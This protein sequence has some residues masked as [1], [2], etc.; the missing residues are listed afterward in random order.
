MITLEIV[1]KKDIVIFSRNEHGER[2]KETITN[3]KPYFYYKDKNGIYQTLF[4]EPCSKHISNLPMD[5]PHDSRSYDVCYENKIKYLQRFMVDRIN[6]PIKK[7]KLRKCFMDIETNDS[8]DTKKTPE[9]IVSIVVYDNYVNKKIDFVWRGDLVERVEG[10][11]YYFNSERKMLNKVL[12]Y[13]MET[14]PDVLIAWYRNEP[15]DWLYLVNRMMK[16]RMA[17]Y[18]LSPLKYVGINGNYNDVNIKGRVVFDLMRAY[19]KSFVHQEMSSYS[20]EDVGKAELGRGKIKSGKTPGQLWKTDIEKLLEYNE[21]DVQ[22]MV[23]LDN[24]YDIVNFYD[25]TRRE[26]GCLWGFLFGTSMINNISLLNKGFKEKVVLPDKEDY[27]DDSVKGAEVFIPKPGLYKNVLVFDVKSLYPKVLSE[28]N[29]SPE[30]VD[31][32]GGEF[33]LG[34]GVSFTNKK[35][36]FVAELVNEQ[37]KLRKKYQDLMETVDVDSDEYQQ[38]YLKSYAYKRI[39]NSW[40][41]LFNSPFCYLYDRNISDSI[42][43]FG[44]TVIKN[45]RDL[46]VEKGRNVIYGDTDSTFLALGN[47]MNWK[48]CIKLG[49]EIQKEIND[50]FV[51]LGKKYGIDNFDLFINF[52]KIYESFIIMEAKKRYVGNLVWKDG[53]EVKK[54]MV[55]AG[56]EVKRSDTAIIGKK[57]Q[58]NIF[59]M[60]LDGKKKKEIQEYLKEEEKKILSNK[61][62]ILE[63]GI[64]KT[65]TV[66]IDKYKVKSAHVRAAEYTNREIFK[67]KHFGS[68]SKFKFIYV[69]GITGLSMTDVFAFDKDTEIPKDIIINYKK[70]LPLLISNKTE[71]LFTALGWEDAKEASLDDFIKKRKNE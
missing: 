7:I 8:V 48:Q 24:K 46:Q 30:T 70:M 20:L 71:R 31:N 67:K 56:F 2:T 60:I 29:M 52:E 42:T 43:W 26:I 23:D 59:K 12:K 51:P 41:G 45:I 68:G 58:S 50:S 38:Y 13:I 33:R 64:P 47:D 62:S 4:G 55:V 36:G 35:T 69:K 32:L 37:F 39:L 25:E 63:L 28:C 15:F 21:E 27:V 44:R 34:N 65:M 17:Y 1:N 9:P 22:L 3:F 19:K 53:Q 66:D 14:D 10:H 18:Y 61:Y 16:L 40:Y 6:K 11:K 54:K 5:V 49:Y 57:I